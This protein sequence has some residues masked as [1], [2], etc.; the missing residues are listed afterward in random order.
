MYQGYQPYGAP[1]PGTNVVHQGKQIWNNFMSILKREPSNP[2]ELQEFTFLNHNEEHIAYLESYCIFINNST[3][4]DQKNELQKNSNKE[5]LLVLGATKFDRD[6]FQWIPK[7]LRSINAKQH[8][9]NTQC[10]FPFPSL[11]GLYHQ[12]T[13]EYVQMKKNRNKKIQKTSNKKIQKTSNKKNIENKDHITAT[14]PAKHKLYYLS[15][16]ALASADSAYSNGQYIAFL[17]DMCRNTFPNTYAWHCGAG[18]CQYDLCQ[19]CYNRNGPPPAPLAPLAPQ[20]NRK[21]T[22]WPPP[23]PTPAPFPSTHVYKPCLVPNTKII[24]AGAA[25][26]IED[27]YRMNIQQIINRYEDTF[28]YNNLY[29]YINYNQDIYDKLF[30]FNQKK[31]YMHPKPSSIPAPVPVPLPSN[32]APIPAPIPAHLPSNYNPAPLPGVPPPVWSVIDFLTKNIDYSVN[33][34]DKT[35]MNMIS[36]SKCPFTVCY[37]IENISKQKFH[38]NLKHLLNE[39]ELKYD[40]I[41]IH[42]RPMTDKKGNISTRKWKVK[43]IVDPDKHLTTLQ[44]C[45][46]LSDL[47]IKGIDKTFNCI[48]YYHWI[49]TVFKVN[50]DLTNCDLVSEIPNL[51]PYKYRNNLYKYIPKIFAKMIPMFECILQRNLRNTHLK[52]IVKAQDYII[53]ENDIFE[54]GIHKDGLFENIA[55]IGIYYYQIDEHIIG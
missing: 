45:N 18:I 27:E 44:H 51:D 4:K 9:Y 14:C 13:K 53:S 55:A 52:V 41:D 34:T 8:N 37:K 54:G 30:A 19:N 33:E 16:D 20:Y 2:S 31:K 48:S 39:Y 43:G 12:Q 10:L 35:K 40:N 23:V 32:P 42:E 49:P 22:Q 50:N 17:C 5:S 47:F 6:S 26:P 29:E 24:I 3:N 11:N 28:I 21:A 7:N 1:I 38:C 15:P 36:V 25:P 46:K